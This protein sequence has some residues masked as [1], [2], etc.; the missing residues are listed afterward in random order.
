MIPTKNLHWLI[1][2]QL[3]KRG[4]HRSQMGIAPDDAPGYISALRGT[5]SVGDGEDRSK[6]VSIWKPESS[7][8]AHAH[9]DGEVL[10]ERANTNPAVGEVPGDFDDI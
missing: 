5:N 1:R 7:Q 6:P 10:T 9:T 3:A 4:G 2:A 8:Y